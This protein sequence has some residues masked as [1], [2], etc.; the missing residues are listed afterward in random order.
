[1]VLAE[2]KIG[3]A[4]DYVRIGTKNDLRMKIENI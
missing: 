3:M 2:K 4:K 1:M